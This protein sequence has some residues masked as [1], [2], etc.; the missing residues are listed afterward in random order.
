MNKTANYQF[1]IAIPVFNEEGNL[2]ALE[3]ALA[4][5][6]PT[7]PMKACV[8]LVD[9]CST[10]SSL[11]MIRAMCSRHENF[12]YVCHSRRLGCSGAMKTAIDAIQSQYMGYTDADLHTENVHYEKY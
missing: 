11:E 9:D 6:L 8:L 4:A 10:D 12:F 1:T 5:Y 7:C 3:E 2:K